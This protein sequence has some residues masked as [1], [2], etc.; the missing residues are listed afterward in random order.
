MFGLVSHIH[1]YDF[2][3]QRGWYVAK[4]WKCHAERCSREL[5]QGMC[6]SFWCF[7][8]SFLFDMKPFG[9]VATLCLYSSIKNLN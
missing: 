3:G 5:C 8:Y 1:M 2:V 7:F 6:Q 4:H 9:N